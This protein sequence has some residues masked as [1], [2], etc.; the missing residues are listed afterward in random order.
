[1]TKM[2]DVDLRQGR[3]VLT[4]L[5]ETI[6]GFSVANGAYELLDE[7]VPDGELGA[8]VTRMLAASRA[9]VPTPDLR[10]GPSPLA[11]AYAALKVRSFRAYQKGT[12]HVSV[13]QT[14]AG[15]VVTPSENR[16]REGF[17]G[18]PDQAIPLAQPDQAELGRAVRAALARATVQ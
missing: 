15:I 16:G 10:N 17:V 13:A 3:Y 2:A 12:R 7:S 14:D 9:G 18:V 6:D 8:A 11:P 1:M 5:S 4:S